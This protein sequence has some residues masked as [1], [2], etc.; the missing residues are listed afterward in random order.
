MVTRIVKLS[1]AKENEVQF[2]ELFRKQNSHIRAMRGCHSLEALRTENENSVI[3]FTY[4]KWTS[5]DDLNTYRS[6]EL[7]GEIWP[8][9]KALFND[10]PEVWTLT[11]VDPS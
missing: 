6:S 11:S 10:K 5:E 3:Y 4:S 1:F 8:K 7:F 9:T 2:L